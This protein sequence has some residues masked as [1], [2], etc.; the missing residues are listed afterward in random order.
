[1]PLSN[2]TYCGI[3]TALRY[4]LKVEMTYASTLRKVALA[5]TQELEVANPPKCLVNA[6]IP[7]TRT[8]FSSREIEVDLKL[9]RCKV[10]IT[11]ESIR[12]CLRIKR[13]ADEMAVQ[14]FCLELIQQEI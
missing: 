7:S 2:D 6:L 4:L 5:E 14:G 12:G 10:N 3:G 8:T 1:M 13:T 9:N 11:C